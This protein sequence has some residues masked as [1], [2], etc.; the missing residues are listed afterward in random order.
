MYSP[1]AGDRGSLGCDVGKR[2]FGLAALD[3]NADA[4]AGRTEAAIVFSQRHQSTGKEIVFRNLGAFYMH[5]L[6]LLGLSISQSWMNLLL[7]FP[8]QIRHQKWSNWR[9]LIRVLN[10]PLSPQF[11]FLFRYLRKPEYR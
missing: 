2:S 1:S 3:A 6:I 9:N 4:G 11:A 8:M 7:A 10:S 5:I